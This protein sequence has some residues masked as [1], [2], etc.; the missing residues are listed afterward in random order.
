LSGARIRTILSKWLK[1][2]ISAVDRT[3]QHIC[4]LWT[5]GINRTVR[6]KQDGEKLENRNVRKTWTD[7]CPVRTSDN[8]FWWLRPVL[9]I[10]DRTR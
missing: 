2:N 10:E 9:S 4:P 7:I 5:F 8:T 1:R 3:K 6:S